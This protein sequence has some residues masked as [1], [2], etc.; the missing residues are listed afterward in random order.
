MNTQKIQTSTNV[1][2]FT[3][4]ELIVVIT[5]LVIIGTIAFLNLGGMSASARDSQRTSDLNQINTQIMVTQAKQGVAYMAMASGTTL[6]SLGTP[7]IGGAPSTTTTYVGGDVN[8]TVLGIDSAKMSDPTSGGTIKYKMGATSLAGT[9]YELAAT[10]EESKTALVMGIYKARTAASPDISTGTG[11]AT[12]TTIALDPADIGKFKLN[13]TLAGIAD[14]SPTTAVCTS[15]KITSVSADLKTL[16]FVCQKA[17]VIAPGGI[18]LAD[19]ETKGL[20]G[21]GSVVV[22]NEGTALP[23]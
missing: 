3:L 1:K 19:N 22:T 11:T 10:L 17:G 7:S 9:A 5:I 23:Y 6:D 18:K 21:S 4:I 16:G 14:V 13:D 12:L 15:T 20:I 2:G 8:Y